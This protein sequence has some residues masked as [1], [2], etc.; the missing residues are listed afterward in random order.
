MLDV[1]GFNY[2][3]SRYALDAELFPERIIVGS[4]TFPDRRSRSMWAARAGVGPRHRRLHLDGLGLHR[5]GRHRPRRLHRRRGLRAHRHGRAVPVPARRVRRPRH[6][7]PPPHRVVLPRDRVRAALRSVDRRA[8]PAASRPSDRDDA[9]VVGRHRRLVELG[10]RRRVAGHGRRVRRRRR[11]RAAA[12]RRLARNGG[13]GRGAGRRSAGQ[14]VRRPVRDRV[15]A[16]RARG[17]R[18]ARRRRGRS[19]GAA[20]GVGGDLASWPGST[21]TSWWTA[22]RMPRSSRSR[23][24]MPRAPCRATST[25]SSP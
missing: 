5:R 8:P 3:D 18:P 1:V 15:P 2:A 6:H 4:E 24:R 11:G 7:R 10:R 12:R 16:G 14:G 13:G 22:R 20:N 25:V 19:H 21:A 9:L 23:W 17:R